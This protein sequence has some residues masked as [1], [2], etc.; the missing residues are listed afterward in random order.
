MCEVS[1]HTDFVW[2][3]KSYLRVVCQPTRS[4]VLPAGLLAYMNIGIT[5]LTDTP[6]AF[7]RGHV[8]SCVPVLVEKADL[9]WM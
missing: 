4:N 9:V 3:V 1:E 6:E 2:D 5:D 8:Q 7:L